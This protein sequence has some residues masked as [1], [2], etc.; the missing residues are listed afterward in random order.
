MQLF[1]LLL[2][3]ESLIVLRVLLINLSLSEENPNCTFAFMFF[4]SKIVNKLG[5]WEPDY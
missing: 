2:K 1:S 3:F 5:V 4:D